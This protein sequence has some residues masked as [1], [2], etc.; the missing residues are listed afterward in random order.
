MTSVDLPPSAADIQR[1][2]GSLS[3][4]DQAT[5]EALRGLLLTET[6][7][8]SKDHKPNLSI[9]R[10]RDANVPKA[11]RSKA[12]PRA[13]RAP[14]DQSSPQDCLSAVQR[15][16]LA[17]NL[18]NEVL[19]SLTSIAKTK[20]RQGDS[21]SKT[22]KDGR[23]RSS[24]TSRAHT[25]L[26]PIDGNR[27][28]TSHSKTRVQDLKGPTDGVKSK[29]G[30]QNAQASCALVAFEYLIFVQDESKTMS[31][32]S[33]QTERGL[34][35]LVQKCIALEIYDVAMQALNILRKRLRL[36]V[37][38]NAT[39]DIKTFGS[40]ASEDL[41]DC[42][43][44]KQDSDALPLAVTTQFQILR[45][46]STGDLDNRR[47]LCTELE[48]A[49]KTGPAANVLRQIKS[50]LP[51]TTEKAVRE[52]A[53]L[54]QLILKIAERW[55]RSL[56]SQPV[57][58]S[59]HAQAALQLGIIALATNSTW[60]NLANHNIDPKKELWLPLLRASEAFQA[61]SSCSKKEKYQVL[62]QAFK[63]VDGLPIR[64]KNLR[65][66][67]LASVFCLLSVSAQTAGERVEAAQWLKRAPD[68]SA[69]QSTL[70]KCLVE[71]SATTAHLRSMIDEPKTH[72]NSLLT[73]AAI[74]CL[75][76][77]LHGDS[78]L[79]DELLITTA[80]LRKAACMCLLQRLREQAEG[81][82]GDTGTDLKTFM[83]LIVCCIKYFD[84]Y[85]GPCP[86][87][88]HSPKVHER[89]THRA[90][91]LASIMGPALE[92]LR[93]IARICSMSRHSI[94]A[95]LD[96]AIRDSVAIL[97]NLISLNVRG[98]SESART[99]TGQVGWLLI[100]QIYWSRSLHLKRSQ[101]KI[102]EQMSCLTFAI[103]LLEK[104]PAE[105]ESLD[106]LIAKLE[107]LFLLTEG[108]GN[109]VRA[110]DI[111]KNFLKRL[112]QD[113]NLA[114]APGACGEILL[115]KAIIGNQELESLARGIQG[116]LRITMRLHSLHPALD[117]VYDATE[118]PEDRRL[119]ILVY[120]LTL[121]SKQIEQRTLVAPAVKAI[122]V[123]WNLVQ[124]LR[125]S[126]HHSITR[127]YVINR[128]LYLQCKRPIS[129]K[130]LS[131]VVEHVPD[132]SSLVSGN[133]VSSVLQDT[134]QL[135]VQQRDV[136]RSTTS[137]SPDMQR[138][139]EIANRWLELLNPNVQTL[140]PSTQIL[141]V[142]FWQCQLQLV[143]GFLDSQNV[144]SIMVK[145]LRISQFLYDKYGAGEEHT[146]LVNIVQLGLQYAALGDIVLGRC[147]AKEA[148]DALQRRDV[149]M[150]LLVRSY[151]ALAKIYLYSSE[152]LTRSAVPFPSVRLLELTV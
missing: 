109:L 120:Q 126:D 68:T 133:L 73:Q 64:G 87:A 48:L 2:A 91:L 86:D 29:E 113:T 119:M 18:I 50:S 27:G 32:S 90:E 59:T 46:M 111:C 62:R 31:K 94:W 118:L 69:T 23:R 129:L 148:N 7:H 123:I 53:T 20:L 39:A 115:E 40:M 76:G 130:I 124:H 88:G 78:K 33:L 30:R 121:L 34:L 17:T 45:I 134:L 98:T 108:E 75:T 150:E 110:L 101:A 3:E 147:I 28:L 44:H 104:A 149:P 70:S 37:N 144:P 55:K 132:S 65:D 72:L 49:H 80:S 143:L 9:A 47:L 106:F 89:F 57:L 52:L 85:L 100:S 107:H 105:T 26:K 54:G 116:Y 97:E 15:T 152:F 1:R 136:L 36:L 146:N 141:D 140:L 43:L 6:H 112:Q 122:E 83:T 151:L 92:A 114:C 13:G 77:D 14:L 61:Q 10:S 81:S 24:P 41:L 42:G 22:C 21:P 127:F 16:L 131:E 93:S 12:P 139:N 5:T 79:L 71:C 58:Q 11:P 137:A 66:D 145:F 51:K 142:D 35:A 74:D 99:N 103:D 138:I 56:A 67:T 8:Q 135:L 128:L 84:R 117:L 19:K 125:P 38:G 63:Y 102:N 60:W 25:P 82:E 96:C 4:C 95:L